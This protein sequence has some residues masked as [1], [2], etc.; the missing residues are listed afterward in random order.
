MPKHIGGLA[1]LNLRKFFFEENL[2]KFA[3]GLHLSLLWYEWQLENKDWKDID[4]PI[5]FHDH[6]NHLRKWTQCNFLDGSMVARAAIKW[7]CSQL[8]QFFFR[9]FLG[10]RLC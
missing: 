9:F 6:K 5:S 2:C 8:L 4:V 7:H 1:S 3:R 10:L